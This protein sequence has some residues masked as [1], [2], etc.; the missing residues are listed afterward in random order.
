MDS[1]SAACVYIKDYLDKQEQIKQHKLSQQRYEAYKS[2]EA[3]LPPM[4]N[5]TSVDGDEFFMGS[6]F[7]REDK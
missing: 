1:I 4:A 3:L 2:K 5:L 6:H 7:I